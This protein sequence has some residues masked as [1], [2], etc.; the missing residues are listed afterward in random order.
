[1]AISRHPDDIALDALAARNAAQQTTPKSDLFRVIRAWELEFRTNVPSFFRDKWQR[2]L[3]QLPEAELIA[4]IKRVAKRHREGLIEGTVESY[5]L[6]AVLTEATRLAKPANKQFPSGDAEDD[7]PTDQRTPAEVRRIA[8][9]AEA[10]LSEY[11][12]KTWNP[13]VLAVKAG[14]SKSKVYQEMKNGRLAFVLRNGRKRIPSPV[15]V[16]YIQ[17][18][19][20]NA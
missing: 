11:T 15:A 7:R 13:R 19:R 3:I 9:L 17:Q 1:M 12:G 6:G 16:A 4:L 10:D 20:L 5:F 2:V 8:A 18:A 14:V